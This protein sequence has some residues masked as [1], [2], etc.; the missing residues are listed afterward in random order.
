MSSRTPQRAVYLVTAAIVAAMVGGFALA[1]ISLGG[2]NTSYQGSQTT[3]VSEI[4]GLSYVSTNLTKLISTVTP[5]TCTSGSPC[6]VAAAG[7]TDCAGGFTGSTTCAAGDWVEQ[8][9]IDTVVATQFVGPVT[10]TLYVTGQPAPIT[11]S[12]STVA[13]TTFYYMESV[14]PSAVE[15]IVIDFDTGTNAHGPGLVTTVSVIATD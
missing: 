15:P 5:T 7:A 8:V 2:T 11:G 4:N 12:P 9:T 6:D 3:T 1:A 13:G 10:L 14:S